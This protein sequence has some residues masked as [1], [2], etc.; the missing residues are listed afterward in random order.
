M[1]HEP[2]PTTMEGEDSNV[3]SLRLPPLPIASRAVAIT[4]QDA[5]TIEQL[6]LT[7][8]GLDKGMKLMIGVITDQDRRLRTLKLAKNKADRKTVPVIVNQHGQPVN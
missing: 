8:E 5:P 4:E 7:V 2:E 6:V 1:I 3:V